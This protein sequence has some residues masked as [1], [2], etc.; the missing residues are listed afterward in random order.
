MSSAPI[1]PYT[2][3]LQVHE[4]PL[5]AD[6]QL[7]AKI[8]TDAA[9]KFSQSFPEFERNAK[10]GTNP[11]DEAT[12]TSLNELRAQMRSIGVKPATVINLNPMPLDFGMGNLYMRG[13]VVPACA[14][15]QPYA[16]YTVRHW[17]HES[18]YNED[19]SRF[20]RAILPIKMAGEFVR[21]FSSKDN[22]G[23]GV[24]ICE[25][26]INPEKCG[27][28][29]MVEIYDQHG[30]P[31]TV[32]QRGIEYDEENN[33]IPVELQVPVK[34]SL[35]QLIDDVRRLRNAFY[36]KTVAIA[37][38]DW[39]LPDGRGKQNVNEVH[40]LMAEL[41]VAEGERAK[42]PDFCTA[43]DKAGLGLSDT[44][45]RACGTTP[46]VGAYKCACGNILNALE[47]YKDFDIQFE[48]AKMAMLTSDEL[49]EAELIK[50]EREDARKPKKETKA[51]KDEKKD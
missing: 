18:L 29:F 12:Q 26:D 47:A 21:E 13:I 10:K 32:T 51:K 9:V 42:L 5:P 20:F 39:N 19:G 16:K 23:G 8:R 4:G 22:Y 35:H 44:N 41:L 49:E 40:R 15:G 46:K 11:L 50:M 1:T 27:A 33:E 48:H 14:P 6:P 28:D 25:G 45:C 38:R 3:P 31:I 24:I 36:K 30:R 17:R 2:G 34:K 7:N 37:E 43:T